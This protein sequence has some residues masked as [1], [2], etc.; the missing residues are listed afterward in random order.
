MLEPF[1]DS[2]AGYLRQRGI[3]AVYV[4]PRKVDARRL[5]TVIGH[6]SGSDASAAGKELDGLRKAALEDRKARG[7]GWHESREAQGKALAS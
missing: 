7:G 6:L 1:E 5:E 2:L 4:S 3:D